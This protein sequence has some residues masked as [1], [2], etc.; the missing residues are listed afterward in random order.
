MK[1]LSKRGL[2][3]Y[4]SEP[5]RGRRSW[6][7]DRAAQAPTYAN[8]RRIKG[9]RGR[10][11]LRKR[12]ETLERNFAHLL[13]TGAMRRVHLRGQVN[14]RKRMLIH[15]GAR[16]LGLVMRKLFRLGTPRALQGLAAMRTALPQSRTNPIWLLLEPSWRLLRALAGRTPDLCANAYQTIRSRR[17]PHR[18][19]TACQLPLKT[20]SA[21]G[22]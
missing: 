22:C 15:A 20:T 16:N 6:K 4:V 14:I 13:L 2:R 21:T 12:G 3:S 10:S 17:S 1:D 7:R 5:R 18:S 8:R 9:R 11:L 19:G